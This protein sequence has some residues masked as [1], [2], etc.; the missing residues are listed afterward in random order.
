[1]RTAVRY[2]AKKIEES[3]QEDKNYMGKFYNLYLR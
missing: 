1:V 3:V 2:A